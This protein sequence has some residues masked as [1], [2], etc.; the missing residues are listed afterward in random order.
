MQSL[1]KKI[2]I[3]TFLTMLIGPSLAQD[4]SIEDQFIT[5]D[6]LYQEKILKECINIYEGSLNNDLVFNEKSLVQ[7]TSIYF[8]S[9]DTAKSL[10]TLE[11]LYKY[12]PNSLY[13]EK[14]IELKI[15]NSTFIDSNKWDQLLPY[16]NKYST[17][18]RY[19]LL[20]ITFI[21]SII[22]IALILIRKKNSL[23][24]L[25]PAILFMLLTLFANNIDTQ[26]IYSLNENK[27]CY[28]RTEPSNASAV[29]LQTENFQKFEVV[30]FNDIWIKVKMDNQYGYIKKS[31]LLFII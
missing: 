14:I 2:F 18:I 6:S 25:V 21:F 8:A 22:W 29:L 28:V 1:T 23:A 16:Y 10:Q 13:L 3:W 26:A 30:D 31:Q 5:A 12:Y 7:M 20:G 17:E 19:T 24:L 27:I 9:N 11:I 15:K 4:N